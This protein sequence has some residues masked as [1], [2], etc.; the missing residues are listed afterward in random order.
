MKVLY[1]ATS[2]PEPDKGAT[3][4]TDLAEKLHETGHELTVA[5][6]E[7]ARN[8]KNTELKKERGFDVLR[9]V[10][11]NY[12]D[13][14]LIEK[15]ITTLKIPILMKKGI[16]KY[17]GDKEFDFIL[18]EA[19]PVTNAGLVAWAKKKFDCPAYL[20]LKDI[21]PQ[22]AVDLGI[23]K[24]NGLLYKYFLTKEKK[25]YQTADTI[26]CMS[27][28]NKNYLVEH[29][30]WLDNSKLEIFPNTKKITKI[31]ETNEYPMRERY[32]IP[33]DACV[34]LFGGNMGRPQFIELLCKAVKECKDNDE[35]YFLFVG[36]GTDRYKLEKTISENKVSNAKLVENLPRDDYEQITKECN[37]GLI[38]LDPKFT[39]PNYP[40]RILSYMEYAKP[41]LAVTDKVTD[42]KDLITEAQCG[43]WVWSGDADAFIAKVKSMANSKDLITQ[44]L[45]GR[46]YIVNNFQ[47]KHSVEILEKHF[48]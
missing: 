19:P 21:F 8:K 7:Q 20:M 15:G 26:G 2:F 36:R 16:T 3:I 28:A 24:Q 43:E 48:K 13:V 40:S 10:T 23:M 12:Y 18:F 47:V 1:I 42:L 38:V 11:G 32:S 6:A 31:I 5:V 14:G 27:L 9:V 35:I 34:F 39:I 45:N 30:P 37:V 22:N 33:K 41:V 17:L 29:N 46:E 4:Y 25:L 44:G